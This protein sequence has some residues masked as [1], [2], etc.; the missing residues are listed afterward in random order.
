MPLKPGKGPKPRLANNDSSSNPEATTWKFAKDRAAMDSQ[1][2]F[3]AA[4]AGDARRVKWSLQAT[5]DPNADAPPVRFKPLHVCAAQGHT[6]AA[7]V[8]IDYEADVGASDNR[9]GLTPLSMAC[10]A[11]HREAV[12][13]LICSEAPLDPKEGSGSTPLIHATFKNFADICE[14]LVCS[15]AD[16]NAAMRQ[17]AAPVRIREALA[18]QN[19]QGDYMRV[20]EGSGRALVEP[21]RVEGIAPLHLA[22]FHGSLR[23][24]MCLLDNGARHGTTDVLLRSAI[25]FAGERGHVEVT[26]LLLECNAALGANLDGHSAATLATRSGHVGV[27]E[28]LLSHGVVNPNFATWVGGPMMIHVASF[29]GRYACAALLCEEEADVDVPLEPDGVCPLML[30]ASRDHKD[31]VHLLLKYGAT[32]N[33]V[34]AEG[35]TAWL[36]AAESGH[37][38]VCNVLS[39]YGAAEQVAARNRRRSVCVLQDDVPE[40]TQDEVGTCVSS[41]VQVKESFS[42]FPSLP[43]APPV[44]CQQMPLACCAHVH[45]NGVPP[46]F[47]YGLEPSS[48]GRVAGL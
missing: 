30:A 15:Q 34:T 17:S 46:G 36:Y 25:M 4:M 1:D 5:A 39:S 8:L 16:V 21:M 28:I 31:V 48:Y 12:R 7:Q 14:L 6:H 2:L 19:D 24:C 37:F 41:A 40:S 44:V 13:L 23:M 18:N 10:L 11:G 42:P 45:F 3:D 22:A 27:V 29:H 35:K 47:G 38:C 33:D 26:S 43:M 9:M 32:V 20:L